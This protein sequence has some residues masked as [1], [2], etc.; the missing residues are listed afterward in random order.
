GPVYLQTLTQ[1]T[2][3][4]YASNQLGNVNVQHS[5]KKNK[6]VWSADFDIGRF[7]RRFENAL[8]TETLIPTTPVQPITGLNTNMP[9]I[10]DI[11]TFRTDY[12][13]PIKTNWKIEAGL[14]SSSV[15][16][17][18]N[19]ELNSGLNG[20]LKRDTGLSNHFKYTE[21]VNAAYVTL[22]G[23]LGAK[24]EVMFGVR[25]EHTHSIG[26]S[27]TFNNVVERNYLNLFPSI[28]ISRPLNKNHRLTGS[29]S[30]RIDRP[31]YQSLN[32]ARG[33]LDPYTYSE[34]NAFLKP[35]YTS[36]IE[37]KHGF[38]DKI[39]TSL[40]ASY[41]TDLQFYVIEPI[42][43]VM[44]RR[45]PENIGKSEAYSLTVSFPV[46]V[47]KG[48]T[49][50]GTLMGNYSRFD[51]TYK[52]TPLHVQQISGSLNASN[53]IVLSKSWTAELTGWLN[54]PGV[55]ALSHTPW[56]GTF[57]AG[58]QKTLSKRW[59]AKLSAQDI[60]HTNRIIERI[61]APNFSSRVRIG[62]DT[63]IVML[64]LTYNFGNQQ[65]KTLRQKKTASEEEV[66]RT[67]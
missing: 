56:L 46:T 65:L 40:A 21:R 50:Q 8:S 42:D 13:Q 26:N 60:L 20:N 51:Y 11:V 25:A 54:T 61:E 48:W 47:R 59:K 33:Y 19:V 41:V 7:N 67:N 10:I 9:A 52:G 49:L 17:D 63:R 32:P 43:G 27:V 2:L 5:F 28:F 64:N 24:T 30:Y 18:N 57:D 23:K 22:N 45:M 31:N 1:K 12:N 37:I 66:Q 16:S 53:A 39:F 55:R 29:Y 36:S 14:K 58:I 15:I 62:F 44:G 4:N 6:A 35:Q 34:G 3:S 38:K